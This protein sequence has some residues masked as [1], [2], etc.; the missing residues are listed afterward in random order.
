M[1]NDNFFSWKRFSAYFRKLWVERWRTNLLRFGILFGL[2][3][4]ISMWLSMMTYPGSRE[5]F[6]GDNSTDPV[7]IPQFGIFA[8]I[9]LLSGCVMATDMLQGARNKSER[10]SALTFPVTPFENWLARWTMSVPL[11][12]IAY[13]TCLYTVDSIRV[14]I[15]G[16]LF[17]KL[18]I[19]YMPLFP[20][21]FREG[22]MYLWLFY[23]YTTAIYVLGGVF[24]PRKPFLKTSVFVF[25]LF[26]IG[27]FVQFGVALLSFNDDHGF[28]HY[29][30]TTFFWASVI[31]LWWLSYLRFKELEVI[32][33]L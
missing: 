18:Y 25:I 10:I 5:Y 11:F 27:L 13:F 21:T 30:L 8:V 15:F 19:A 12:I 2:M 17:N 1:L 7:H 31:L 28:A 23:F 4:L 14:A 33:R 32:D 16:T 20:S 6:S 24:F 22:Q 26:W 29:A 3:L 9:F